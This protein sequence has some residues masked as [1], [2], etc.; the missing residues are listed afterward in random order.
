MV[1][2]VWGLHLTITRIFLAG[3][4]TVRARPKQLI[5]SKRAPRWREHKIFALQPSGCR[6]GGAAPAPRTVP[7]CPGCAAPGP[8]RR[9]PELPGRSDGR[10]KP[11]GERNGTFPPWQAIKTPRKPHLPLRSGSGHR[12]SR[13][14]RRAKG[15]HRCLGPARNATPARPGGS[16]ASPPP[17]VPAGR[18]QRGAASSS[19]GFVPCGTKPAGPRPGSETR[20]SFLSVG[21][22]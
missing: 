16:S 7:V 19:R 4:A 5:R 9:P 21:N 14:S 10:K 18:G 6:S 3:T 15:G 12:R 8:S 22:F 13:L 17:S 1:K 11:R 2:N 20:S